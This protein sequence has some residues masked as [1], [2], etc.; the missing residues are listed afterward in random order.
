MSINA[1]NQSSTPQKRPRLGHEDPVL[2]ELWAV[3]VAL[4]AE[5]GYS[6]E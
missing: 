4:N 1:E 5:V 2:Q 3:K 6:I